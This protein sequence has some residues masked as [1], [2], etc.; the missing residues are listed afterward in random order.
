MKKIVKNII[1]GGEALLLVLAACIIALPFL[2]VLVPVKVFKKQKYDALL[3]IAGIANC[4]D[5]FAVR[6]KELLREF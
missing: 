3:F 4:F 6:F 2:I 1:K 5:D